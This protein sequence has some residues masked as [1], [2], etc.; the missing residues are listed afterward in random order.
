MLKGTSKIFWRHNK[1]DGSTTVAESGKTN[2]RIVGAEVGVGVGVD[3]LL[4]VVE[5]LSA[6]GV[7]S[8]W[9]RKCV[10]EISHWEL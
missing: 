2:G 1:Y 4:S 7:P 10:N 9:V 5:E 3:G 8:R 6:R